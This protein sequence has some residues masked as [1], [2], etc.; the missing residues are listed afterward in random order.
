MIKLIV[1]I[2]NTCVSIDKVREQLKYLKEAGFYSITINEYGQWL[3]GNIRLKEGAILVTTNTNNS[4]LG[5]IN[6]ESDIKIELLDNSS[7][8]FSVANR[9]STKSSPKDNIESYLV[10]NSTSLEDFKR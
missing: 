6:T 3:D 2:K 10:K 5:V 4:N 8:K 9:K 7:L 1:V